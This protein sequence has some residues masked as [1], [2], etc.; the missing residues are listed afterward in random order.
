MFE[1][2]WQWL[3]LGLSA[4]Y[5]GMQN[6]LAGG[7]TFITFPA[8]LLAGLDPLGANMTSTVALFPGQITVAATVRSMAEGVGPMSLR[9]LVA[10]SLAGG[11]VGAILLEFTPP[12][13]F[14]RLVPWLVL[15]ATLVFFWGS[16]VR[17]PSGS[18]P[19]R[20]LSVGTLSGLQLAISIYG[21]YFGGGI[22]FLM[23]A[24]LTVAGQPVRAAGATKNVLAM[25]MNAVATLIFATSGRVQ[26]AFAGIICI[27]ALAG[28]VLGT[29]LLR[30]LPEKLLRGFVVAVGSL[31]TVWLF[32]RGA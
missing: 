17:R 11:V 1:G 31:L 28:G 2:P 13:F 7:G 23:L 6:A 9:K 14:A 30:R 25:V 10:I 3:F 22:G 12:A 24:V 5:A 27:C 20:R 32:A 29:W 16:F 21:G 18:D 19:A 8:L 4:F 15:F 26:W